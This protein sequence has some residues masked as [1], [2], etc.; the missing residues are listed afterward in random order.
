MSVIFRAMLPSPKYM[1]LKCVRYASEYAGTDVQTNMN[2][3]QLDMKLDM[4][5]S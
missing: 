2:P 3:I 1:K 4:S 5:P